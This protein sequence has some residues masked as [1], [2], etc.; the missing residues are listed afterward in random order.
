M[1]ASIQPPAS[2]SK[3]GVLWSAWSEDDCDSDPHI[4]PMAQKVTEWFVGRWPIGAEEPECRV[5][6]GAGRSAE[7]IAR[8]IADNLTSI[9]NTDVIRARKASGSDQPPASSCKNMVSAIAVLIRKHVRMEWHGHDHADINYRSTEAA[10]EAIA[11]ILEPA[12]AEKGDQ[13]NLPASSGKAL[14]GKAQGAERVRH[15]KRGTE[16]EVLGEAEA[17]V[18]TVGGRVLG[19]YDKLTVYRGSDGKLWCRFTDEMR[20][21]RFEPA[22]PASSGQGGR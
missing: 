4:D 15:V 6:I 11:A 7:I 8:R 2:Y 10:A 22:P 17:Q 16:Y 12:P 9:L 18:S 19:D 5:L 21:G 20:D 13:D 1:D 14:T 3:P